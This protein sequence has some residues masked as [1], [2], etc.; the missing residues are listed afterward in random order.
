MKFIRKTLT[1]E[2]SDMTN[3]TFCGHEMDKNDET[4]NVDSTAGH[5]VNREDKCKILAFAVQNKQFESQQRVLSQDCH[6]YFQ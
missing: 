1:T 5:G 4:R 2:P 6:L 3:Y